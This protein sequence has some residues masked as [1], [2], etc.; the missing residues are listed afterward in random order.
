MSPDLKEPKEPPEELKEPKEQKPKLP[1]A[2]IA[3]LAQLHL[4]PDETQTFEGELEAILDWVGQLQEVDVEHV[5][6]LDT[7]AFHTLTLEAGLRQ[8][9]VSE[10]NQAEAL[11]DLAADQAYGFYLV[12]RVVE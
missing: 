4:T 7:A 9:Q 1:V 12:P 6:V 11:L 5:P 2:R 3:A 10:S 8:D